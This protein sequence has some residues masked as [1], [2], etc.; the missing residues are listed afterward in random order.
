MGL[1]ESKEV[2]S[3]DNPIEWL[4][5]G[6]HNDLGENHLE[7]FS[8]ITLSDIGAV[9]QPIVAKDALPAVSSLFSFGYQTDITIVSLA[10]KVCFEEKTAPSSPFYLSDAPLRAPPFCA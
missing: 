2:Q 3:T 1:V 5:S 7:C 8:E 4:F 6:F 10:G 9:A